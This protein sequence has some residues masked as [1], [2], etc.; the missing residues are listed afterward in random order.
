MNYVPYAHPRLLASTGA[1]AHWCQWDRSI[2]KTWQL[3]ANPQWAKGVGYSRTN[4]SSA[5]ALST[6]LCDY[7]EPTNTCH[8]W[9][10]TIWPVSTLIEVRKV[11][12][13]SSGVDLRGVTLAPS[14]SIACLICEWEEELFCTW[15]TC[16]S[17]D[18]SQS[19]NLVPMFQV[20]DSSPYKPNGTS[21]RMWK[22]LKTLARSDLSQVFVVEYCIFGKLFLYNMP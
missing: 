17:S 14:C 5:S 8:L 7:P 6:C 11:K 20:S 10:S 12:S 4:L 21:I 1:S 18:V 22:A 19:L 9:S 2:M 15:R 3:P 13:T 16:C